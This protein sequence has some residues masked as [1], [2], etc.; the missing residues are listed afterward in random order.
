VAF[1]AVAVTVFAPELEKQSRPAQG[2]A[3][4]VNGS[5]VQRAASAQQHRRA[6][7]VGL[8]RAAPLFAQPLGFHRRLI[9]FPVP[10]RRAIAKL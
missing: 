2:H 1:D 9:P 7:E 10:A 3:E 5:R 6:R 8:Q 4:I